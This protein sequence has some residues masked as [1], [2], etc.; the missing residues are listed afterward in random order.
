MVG[1][2]VVYSHGKHLWLSPMF[3]LNHCSHYAEVFQCLT[4]LVT[5]IALVAH[6]EINNIQR[7]TV[8]V[9]WMDN[10]ACS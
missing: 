6:Q 10:M 7:I 9:F 4:Y 2:I 3:F 8:I 1:M 5:I